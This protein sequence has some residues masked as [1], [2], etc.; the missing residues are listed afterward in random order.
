MFEDPVMWTG[1]N[2]ITHRQQAADRFS[3]R[4]LASK[5]EHPNDTYVAI[6]HSHGGSVIAYAL[7]HE[8]AVSHALDGAA[9]LATPFIDIR[10]QSAWQQTVRTLCA[11]FTAALWVLLTVALIDKTFMAMNVGEFADLSVVLV[12]LASMTLGCGLILITPR[13]SAWSMTLLRTQVDRLVANVS[14]S[15]LPDGPAYFFSRSPGD[16]A[17]GLLSV[18]QM[19]AWPFMRLQARL[20]SVLVG[21]VG[22]VAKLWR[23]GRIGRSIIVA[24]ALFVALGLNIT[25]QFYMIDRVLAAAFSHDEAV[26]KDISVWSSIVRTPFSDAVQFDIESFPLWVRNVLVPALRGAMV[27]SLVG[28][29]VIAAAFAVFVVVVLL[30]SISCMAFGASLWSVGPFV[31]LVVEPVPRGQWALHR[32]GWDP[33][34][35]SGLSHSSPYSSSE[36]L[37][38]LT[39][40]LQGLRCG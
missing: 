24:A 23:S 18:L 27:F 26:S 10:P 5:S 7:K 28:G 40:W 34:G 4:L 30:A 32:L 37:S 11:G 38:E 20:S 31:E 39:E 17:A 9:F 36:G 2:S 8:P 14:T 21:V 16:E 25:T 15:I 29:A 22:S 35:T 13:V 1:N 12:T 6:G 33:E 19:L 3:Q